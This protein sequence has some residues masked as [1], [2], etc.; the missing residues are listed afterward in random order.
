[1]NDHRFVVDPNLDP[2]IVCAFF[3]MVLGSIGII[4]INSFRK[5]IFW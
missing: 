4:D 2:G 1:L 3:S 5:W